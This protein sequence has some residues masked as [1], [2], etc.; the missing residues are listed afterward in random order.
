[1]DIRVNRPLD[2]PPVSREE[3]IRLALFW[4]TTLILVV[5]AS[6]AL[7]ALADSLRWTCP[8]CGSEA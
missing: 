4:V 7:V 3:I 6:L 5:A 1:M 2:S 8:G